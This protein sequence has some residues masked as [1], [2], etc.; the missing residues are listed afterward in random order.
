MPQSISVDK[1]GP[2]NDLV[3]SGNEALREQKMTQIFVAI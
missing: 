3:T 1:S 2:G